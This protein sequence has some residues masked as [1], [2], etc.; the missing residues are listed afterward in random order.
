MLTLRSITV[1]TALVTALTVAKAARS[2]TFVINNLDGPG[3]GFNDATPVATVGGNG[4]TTLGAQRLNAFQAA[5]NIWGISLDSSITIHIDASMDPLPCNVSS[6]VL[7]SAGP[8]TVSSDFSGAPMPMHWYPAALANSLASADLV[9]SS[10]DIDVTFNSN[11]G[12]PD[13]LVGNG[14]YL[15]LD[16]DT[17]GLVDLVNVALHEFAHGLGFISFT[18]GATGASLLDVP[19]AFAHF[20]FDTSTGKHW[21][22]MTNLERASSAQRAR[23]VVWDGPKVTTAVP[24]KLVQGAVVLTVSAL[25]GELPIGLADFGPL[26]TSTPIAGDVILTVDAGGPT[27]SDGCESISANLFGKIPLIDRGNCLFVDKVRHAQDAGASAVLI[28]DNVSGSPPLALGGFDSSITIPSVRITL[29]A[30][31]A[32]KNALGSGPVSATLVTDP[33]RYIGADGA[34]RALMFTP[35][36]IVSGSS[37][38]HWDPLASPNLLMEPSITDNPSHAVDLT[39]PLLLDLGWRATVVSAVPVTS[40]QLSAIGLLGFLAVGLL[41]TRRRHLR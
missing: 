27:T 20:M 14:W 1:A 10:A 21:D 6:A 18:D 23:Y 8:I 41:A 29:D 11:L 33:T 19:D 17:G 5:A 38:S 22:V 3:E 12:Q 36:P 24:Q 25:P 28:A 16:G 35:Q 2:A 37:L 15:G 7:G 9:P 34:H 39:L 13:C 40:R 30:G 4:G 32:L 31:T 26:P